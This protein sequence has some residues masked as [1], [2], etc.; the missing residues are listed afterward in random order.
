MGAY[1]DGCT[2]LLANNVTPQ[3]IFGQHLNSQGPAANLVAVDALPRGLMRSN[4]QLTSFVSRRDGTAGSAPI[5]SFNCA[6]T[7]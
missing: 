5:P 2:Q 6:G 4:D 1:Q 7:S 3:A